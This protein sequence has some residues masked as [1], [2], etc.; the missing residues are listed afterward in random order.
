MKFYQGALKPLSLKSMSLVKCFRGSTILNIGYHEDSGNAIVFDFSKEKKLY[1][2]AFKFYK[3]REVRFV[4]LISL[5]KR[6]NL[7]G[8]KKKLR[9]FS[10]QDWNGL[11]DFTKVKIVPLPSERRFS[12]LYK[13]KEVLSLSVGE[14]RELPQG[15]RELF[16][17]K[18]DNDS[19]VCMYL[20][21]YGAP[22]CKHEEE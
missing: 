18:I 17:K 3:D 1:R 15:L 21:I 11:I 14:I 9:E 4:K 19:E 5:D 8:V 16:S 10:N 22:K 13:E 20:V 12:F 6:D 7:S 2:A